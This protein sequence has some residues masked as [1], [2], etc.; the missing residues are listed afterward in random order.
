MANRFVRHLRTALRLAVKQPAAR[1]LRAA[2]R[3]VEAAALRVQAR[4]ADT[5]DGTEELRR[6]LRA[7]EPYFGPALAAQQGLPRRH[8]YMQRVV[9][10]EC[11]GREE[12]FQILEIGSW[13][14]GSAITWAA[15]LKEYNGGRGRVVCVD[16]WCSYFAAEEADAHYYA[17]M[18]Q[19]LQSGDIFQ[20][21][22]HNI[23]AGGHEDVI[24]VLKA[25]SD[26]A[27]ALLGPGRFDLIFVDGDHSYAAVAADLASAAPLLREG[28]ILCGDD[29]EVQLSEADEAAARANAGRD[30]V[31]D[32]RTGQW[33]HPGVTLAV[34]EAVGDVSVWEG[35]WAVRKRGSGWEKLAA[36]PGPGAA[37]PHPPPQAG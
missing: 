2:A 8:W 22:L 32:P 33:F 10:A 24:R 17:V 9:E 6:R 31:R 36:D 11:Q 28:G 26:E 30:Y 12:P 20:L 19:A 15:A 29:L 7:G 5:P 3:A 13:A 21:F 23:R 4:L 25:P 37:R 16:P 14:G 35:F 34:A 1:A 27:L 18:E